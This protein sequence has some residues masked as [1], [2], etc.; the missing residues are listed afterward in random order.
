MQSAGTPPTQRSRSQTS[1]QVASRARARLDKQTPGGLE[2]RLL[3]RARAAGFQPGDRLVVGFSGGRDSLALAAALRRVASTIDVEPQLVHVDHRLREASGEEARRAVALA[4]ALGLD[5]EVVA[6]E[7]WPERVL[8]GTGWEEAARDARYQALGD[9]GR[10]LR[11]RAVATA[12]H[13]HDQ[14]ETV[15]LHLLRGA[16]L[17]GAG[18]MAERT[19]L[20][21]APH[22]ISPQMTEPWL[23]RPLLRES[24]SEIERYT[25]SLGLEPVEDPSNQDLGPRRN[26]VRHEILPR[27]EA[28]AP[29]AVGA[30][31][32]FAALAADDDQL[33]EEIAA[34]ALV[35][36][37][38]PGGRLVSDRL[39][40]QA[41]ALQRR[42]V[43]QWLR[44][45]AGPFELSAERTEAVV[46][47]AVAG[48]GAR[49]VEVGEGWTVRC[50]R[51]MLRAERRQGEDRGRV[52]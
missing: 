25:A 40:V 17:H 15:V 41:P 10:E 46:A 6:L 13:E 37:V 1:E 33:L 23:W 12:H 49:E 2:Q 35:E 5:C 42:M 30:L 21:S 32:R 11:A 51:G 4:H 9:V 29:G 50:E 36:A 44:A 18:G 16:G 47:K 19:R 48:S 45:Q 34:E 20:P 24:R 3:A 7:A 39:R 22:D 14:A 52:E 43:R 28:L 8:S 27:L 38:D 26:R 31:A